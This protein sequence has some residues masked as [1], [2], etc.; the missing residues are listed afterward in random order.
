MKTPSKRL[1]I[2]FLTPQDP[3]NKRSWSGTIPFM[4]KALQEHCGDVTFLG[5]VPARQYAGKIFN[6]LTRS[7]L[8]KGF[9]YS[10]SLSYA[11]Q[12]ARFFERKLADQAFDVI[13][14]PAASVG[15]ALLKTELPIVYA[16][17]V[18][19]ALLNNYYPE[20]TGLLTR[21]VRDGHLIE[22]EALNRSRVALFS[23]RWAGESAVK[24]YGVAEEKVTVIPFGANIETI[25][26]IDTVLSKGRSDR[27]K[28]LF[29]AVNWRR[30]GGDLAL[31]TLVSLLHRGVD[32]ELIV[33]GCVPPDGVRHER[34]TV[35]PFLSKDDPKQKQALTD[36]FLSA[37]FL[38]LPT[39]FDCTPIVFCEANA[40]GL[41]VVTTDTGGVSSLVTAG[42]NGI[43]LPLSAGADEYASAIMAAYSSD[44]Y[45]SLVRS[46]RAAF[47]KR[48]N[49]GS[50]AAA[51]GGLF[52]EILSTA[53]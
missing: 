4:A 14:A 47:D 34:M 2:G 7:L 33:C 42:E 53:K 29:L 9:D 43:M 27:L 5:P 12:C 25:P 23:S 3:L 46:S 24:D 1:R 48:L 13:F 36:L 18:T 35:I 22:Q 50:W 52:T 26:P 19:F 45:A 16:S 10:H 32:A 15:I 8:G 30:K 17:D 6:R 41:P 38:L 39:R 11:R 28:L 20:F 44:G 21:S 51:V 49:W 37:D 31:E 40:Y